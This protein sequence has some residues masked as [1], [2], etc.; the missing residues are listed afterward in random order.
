MSYEAFKSPEEI[1]KYDKIVNS[2]SGLRSGLV[3]QI[4][5]KEIKHFIDSRLLSLCEEINVEK[6]KNL[7]K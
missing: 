7:K 3:A 5:N 6:M 1:K 2:I 4:N